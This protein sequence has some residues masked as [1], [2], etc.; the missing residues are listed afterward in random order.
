MICGIVV[1]ANKNSI[2]CH[3]RYLSRTVNRHLT[4]ILFT[5]VQGTFLSGDN[6]PVEL[7]IRGATCARLKPFPKQLKDVEVTSQEAGKV[8]VLVQQNVTY[9]KNTEPSGF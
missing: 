7:L 2:F 1:L 9:P 4:G 6:F 5:G 3:T 8:G